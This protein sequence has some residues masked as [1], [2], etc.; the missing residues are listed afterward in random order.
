MQC[1]EQHFHCIRCCK[2]SRVS[3]KYKGARHIDYM[4]SGHV[5]YGRGASS[6]LGN[7]GVWGGPSNNPLKIPKDSCAAGNI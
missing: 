7:S 6:D 2:S 3:V 1:N 4:Q 5:T